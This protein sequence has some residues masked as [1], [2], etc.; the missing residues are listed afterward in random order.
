MSKSKNFSLQKYFSI[1]VF[2]VI[3]WSMSPNHLYF[4]LIRNKTAG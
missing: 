4:L 1:F 2:L 3:L